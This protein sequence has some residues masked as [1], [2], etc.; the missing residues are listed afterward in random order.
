MQD[1]YTDWQDREV[2]VVHNREGICSIWPSQR[3]NACGWHDAGC[4]GS[5]ADCLAFI[6]ANCDRDARLKDIP[7]PVS[8]HADN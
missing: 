6:E 5:K 1:E 2:K 8:D 7:L 4:V 3:E